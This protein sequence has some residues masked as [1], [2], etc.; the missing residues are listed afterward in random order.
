MPAMSNTPGTSYIK[1]SSDGKS[2]MLRVYGQGRHPLIDYE[3]GTHKDSRKSWHVQT[4]KDTV[5]QKDHR[6]MTVKEKIR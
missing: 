3:Y 6:P 5:R 2:A 4:W 1:V